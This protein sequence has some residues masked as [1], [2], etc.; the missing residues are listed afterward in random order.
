ML[1]AVADGG[2]Q[3]LF[4]V[5]AAPLGRVQ[6]TALRHDKDLPQEKHQKFIVILPAQ[7][8]LLNHLAENPLVFR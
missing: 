3:L 6:D 2:F 8:K 7:L 4:V 5:A 1:L